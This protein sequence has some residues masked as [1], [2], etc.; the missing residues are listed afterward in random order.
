[1][2]IIEENER[3]M[4]PTLS[5]IW[6]ESDLE[7]SSAEEF[8]GELK[9]S[10]PPGNLA[11]TEELSEEIS[12]STADSAAAMFD[13]AYLA[14]LRSGDDET[15]RHFDHYFRRRVRAK[16]WGKFSRLREEDLIDEIMAAAIQNIMRGRPRDA[17]RLPAYV[18]G[19]CANLIRRAM[20]YPPN[21][22][23]GDFDFQRIADDAKTAEQAMQDEENAEAVRRTLETLSQ[24]DRQVLLDVFGNEM[25][26][27]AACGKYGV[28]G[29]Q[30]RQILFH[31]RGRFRK[32]WARHPKEP[33][34]ES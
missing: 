5:H 19:I 15:A 34:R 9:Q 1:M 24:R 26:R 20:R 10:G 31:A 11:V 21:T 4:T 7:K 8:A 14:R 30:L 6:N 18:H 2:S 27:K 28:T 3:T 13:D 17:G 16:A 33:D 12:T 29:A 23:T 32:N 25:N 22:G